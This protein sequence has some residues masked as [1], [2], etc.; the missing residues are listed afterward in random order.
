MHELTVADRVWNRACQG[1]G[2]S[3]RAGDSALAALLLFHGAAMNGGVL[4]AVESLSPDELAGALAGYGCFGYKGI[5][6]LIRTALDAIQRDQDLD[7]L[8]AKLDQ[9]YWSQIPDDGVLVKAFEVHYEATPQE[10]SPLV[11]D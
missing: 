3:P 6:K 7:S 9:E 8:E 1:G 11:G 10:Y 2:D 4:H 5:A